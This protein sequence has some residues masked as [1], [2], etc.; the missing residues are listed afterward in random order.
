MKK[1]ITIALAVAV[2]FSFAACQ[3]PTYK[4]ID[5]ISIAQ[6]D[7]ILD[8]E[9]VTPDMFEV[10]ANYTDGTSGVISAAIDLSQANVASAT[11]TSYGKEFKANTD[12][13]LTSIE[14][15]EVSGLSNVSVKAGTQFT[16]LED[17]EAAYNAGT[18]SW[19]GEPV[20]TLSYDGG[21]KE[22]GLFDIDYVL[23]VYDANGNMLG[24]SNAFVAGG[25]YTVK[26]EKVRFTKTAGDDWAKI[27]TP[28]VDLG[29]E[30]T[31]P[32]AADPVTVDDIKVYYTVTRDMDGDGAG[33]AV[34][35]AEKVETLPT[36][37]TQDS[38]VISVYAVNSDNTESENPVTEAVTAINLT[39]GTTAPTFTSG[40][41]AA[42]TVATTTSTQSVTVAGT[43]RVT[44]DGEIYQK[45]FS[46]GTGENYIQSVTLAKQGSSSVKA[47]DT[48][49]TTPYDATSNNTGIFTSTI[50]W[51][52][53]TPANIP[54][55]SYVS[56]G[57]NPGVVPAGITS[58]NF[59][60]ICTATYTACG[61]E[62]VVNQSLQ[63]SVTK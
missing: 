2:L 24:S 50:A 36:L 23:S 30:I 42:V 3:Q 43:V 57:F 33:K 37:Y 11:V 39:A 25:T 63:F 9:T 38:V 58:S 26:M 51:R 47:G 48:L 14:G 29:I 53:T 19:E 7:I 60:T 27:F 34:T 13:K 12:I 21:S 28:A 5:T 22:Y 35:V 44:I 31:V 32:A 54:A 40:K 16:A 45:P 18:I 15:V 10:T 8:G 49:N 62:K 41:S 55:G 61:Q 59:D 1:F 4:N 46:I 20:V 56:Y 52:D 17:L 6:K